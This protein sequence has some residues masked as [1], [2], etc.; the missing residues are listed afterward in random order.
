MGLKYLE[1]IPF[2]HGQEPTLKPAKRL[3]IVWYFWPLL[4]E[5]RVIQKDVFLLDGSLFL[6]LGLS[7]FFWVNQTLLKML[8]KEAFLLPIYDWNGLPSLG[9]AK[10]TTHPLFKLGVHTT[11]S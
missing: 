6:Y 2:L 10:D 7:V 11:Q 4:I 1:Q 3:S 8:L 9:M 5:E